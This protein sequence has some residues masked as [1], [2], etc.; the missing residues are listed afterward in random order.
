ML[1]F[2]TPSCS[3]SSLVSPWAPGLHPH[4]PVCSWVGLKLGCSAGGAL[5][6]VSYPVSGADTL[7]IYSSSGMVLRQ[8]YLSL[9]TSSIL[10]TPQSSSNA[11]KEITTI[12]KQGKSISWTPASGLM[13]MGTSS[14]PCIPNPAELCSFSPQLAHTHPISPKIFPT[15]WLTDWE[16]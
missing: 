14:L 7:M 8:S 4:L 3:C 10:F 5:Q 16:E 15:P 13:M 12:L 2:L 6:A 1:F 9:L 11:R